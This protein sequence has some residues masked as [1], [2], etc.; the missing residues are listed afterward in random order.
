MDTKKLYRKI[1][2]YSSFKG[3]D[4]VDFQTALEH[5]KSEV[6]LHKRNWL[7]ACMK[8]RDRK[9]F[10]CEHESYTTPAMQ[11]DLAEELESMQESPKLPLEMGL[12][13]VLAR[14]TLSEV[15]MLLRHFSNR[16][17]RTE[18]AR[19]Y[20]LPRNTYEYRIYKIMEKLHKLLEKDLKWV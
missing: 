10:R 8:A 13:D 19:F 18:V 7:W 12:R 20:R 3:L 1:V 5:G 16:M 2:S 9:R 4:P 6:P 17:N 11:V 14:L 15:K